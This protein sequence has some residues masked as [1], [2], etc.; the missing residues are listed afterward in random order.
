LST[1]GACNVYVDGF[2]LYYG[3]L[4]G[5]PHKWL[6]LGALFRMI[7]PQYQ[8]HRIRHFTAKVKAHPND[9][10]KPS[11]QDAYLRA[12]QTIPNLTIH[13]GHFLSSKTRMPNAHPP[14]NTVEVIKTEEKG[15]DVNLASYLLIDAFG[16]DFER[17][18]VVSNDS[19]LSFPI[20]HVTQ[21]LHLPVTVPNPHA[22][23]SHELRRVATAV[24][25]LRK[26]PVQACQFAPVIQNSHGNVTKPV[27]W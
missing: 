10:T 4:K 6:D 2:N 17:A 8:I 23:P 19:D 9:P 25:P 16:G 14:P 5:S 24:R 26:G 18:V 13:F 12:L 15:S 3:L 22:K 11:R 21:E 1:T 20:E 27:C 7:F